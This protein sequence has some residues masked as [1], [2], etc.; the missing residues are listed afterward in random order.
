MVSLLLAKRPP[1]PPPPPHDVNDVNDVNDDTL[2]KKDIFFV[3]VVVV[4]VVVSS[5][6][7]SSF[8]VQ[9]SEEEFFLLF[10]Q[11]CIKFR[12]LLINPKRKGGREKKGSEKD[13]VMSETYITCIP[14]RDFD[15]ERERDAT[16][17]HKRK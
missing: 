6:S 10:F 11:N 15:G 9:C 17:T 4:V 16:N 13:G 8:M 1:P 7:S 5:S 12:A 14:H 2:F 3:V